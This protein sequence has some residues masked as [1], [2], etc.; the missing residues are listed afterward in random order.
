MLV[1]GGWTTWSNWG[2]CSVTCEFGIQRRHRN[3]TN[4][5]PS[6]F[7]DHCFGDTMDDRVCMVKACAGKFLFYLDITLR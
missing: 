2:A 7:G 6:R 1:H 4:P 3:C 5:Y